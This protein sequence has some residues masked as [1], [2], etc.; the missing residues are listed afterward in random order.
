MK[1]DK[2]RPITDPNKCAQCGCYE[3]IE[4]HH[5]IPKSLGGSFVVPLCFKCHAFV[6]GIEKRVSTSNLVK[7]KLHAKKINGEW[8]GRPPYGFAV[9]DGKLVPGDGFEHVV[10]IVNLRHTYRRNGRHVHSIRKILKMMIILDPDGGWNLKRVHY[11][12]KRWNVE[13][14]KPYKETT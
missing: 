13:N 8:V 1:K 2:F 6:H 9:E 7:K 10:R 14:L 3:N 12:D 5:P 11:I 4:M